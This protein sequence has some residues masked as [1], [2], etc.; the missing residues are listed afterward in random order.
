MTGTPS[1][2]TFYIF[3]AKIAMHRFNAGTPPIGA[4]DFRISGQPAV[5]MLQAGWQP[6]GRWMQQSALDYANRV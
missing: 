1:P 2:L 5:E 6:T 4:A 3:I